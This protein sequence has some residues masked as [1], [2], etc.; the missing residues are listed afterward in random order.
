[1]ESKEN[2]NWNDF[3]KRLMGQFKRYDLWGAN[4][5]KAYF[6]LSSSIEPTKNYEGINWVVKHKFPPPS[7]LGFNEIIN[8]TNSTIWPVE[9]KDKRNVVWQTE[10]LAI[11]RLGES[12][13]SQNVLRIN[14]AGIYEA[15]AHIQD[16][17]S[18][19]TKSSP[20]ARVEQKFHLTKPPAKK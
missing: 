12:S 8:V 1:M 14:S 16:F 7:K 17:T 4:Y 11:V 10:K 20:F 18:P 9:A 3:E 2:R 6:D 13:E 5:S 19:R 15:Y